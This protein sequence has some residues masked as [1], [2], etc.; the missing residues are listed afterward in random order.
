M[1]LTTRNIPVIV[2]CM[3]DFDQQDRRILK[4][5]Q[6]DAGRP[7]EELAEV[8]GLSRNATWRRIKR[9]EEQGVLRGRVALVDPDALGLGL[10]VF[11]SVKTDRHDAD[12]AG[13]FAAVI[14]DFPE[15]LGWPP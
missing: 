7:V 4:E 5:L 3:S 12:W 15:I 13:K 2:L 9:L 14:R 11:I 6:R 1:G 8:I 10:I